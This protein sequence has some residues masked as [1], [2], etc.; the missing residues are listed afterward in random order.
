VEVNETNRSYHNARAQLQDIMKI[1]SSFT[2][3]LGLALLGQSLLAQ[4]TGKRP[5]VLQGPGTG[6]L[7][8]IAQ[9]EVPVG[10]MFLDGPTTRAM[11][12]DR[13]ERTS[14]QELGFLRPTN[15]EWAV[16]F[17]FSDI[18]YV[19]DDDKDKLDAP[20]LLESY[21]QGTAAANK[22]REAA[23]RA[24]IIIVGWEQEPKYDPDTHNLT[25]ALR[26]TSEGQA[27]LN[28]NT[29]LLG[30]K[31]VM[32]VVLVCDSDALAGTLP[33]FN[34]LLTK[35]KFQ[36]G[37]SY[38]EY[39]PGDKVAKYGLAAL[40]LGGVGVGAAKL[41]LFAWLAVAF[42]KFFKLIIVGVIAVVAMFKNAIAK[43][44]G[45]RNDQ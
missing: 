43:L 11:M 32:E 36:T 30:R 16:F 22:E 34:Q 25:W 42:K 41:G 38:A 33:T 5:G 44:F 17:E 9:I 2:V 23:G 3:I 35:H 37:E 15:G 20:K 31:G 7:G 18:G 14:G 4:E 10:Y 21:K 24:P 1:K 27:F 8:A 12:E 13:G 26:A 28:Y 29:R 40:V 39:R 45:R 19:K 6:K